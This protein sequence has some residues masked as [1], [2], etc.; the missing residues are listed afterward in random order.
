MHPRRDP[1]NTNK[2]PYEYSWEERLELGRSLIRVEDENGVSHPPGYLPQTSQSS[3]NKKRSSSE[4]VEEKTVENRNKKLCSAS[5][6]KSITKVN[7]QQSHKLP[8]KKSSKEPLYS[9]HYSKNKHNKYKL[10]K[11][12]S[13]GTDS[14]HVQSGDVRTGVNKVA[15]LSNVHSENM[16]TTLATANKE[17]EDNDSSSNDNKRHDK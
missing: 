5:S 1:K 9:T 3:S 10:G 6:S 13:D 16:T 11:T 8:A 15:D 12:N 2:A 14:I 7:K 17:V 4:T